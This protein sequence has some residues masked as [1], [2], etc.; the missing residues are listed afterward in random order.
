[1]EIQK[2][3][4]ILEIK[5]C[6]SLTE[7]D[8]KTAYFRQARKYHPD[9]L[10]QETGMDTTTF[11]EIQDAYTCVLQWIRNPQLRYVQSPSG[12]KPDTY[13]RSMMEFISEFKLRLD[14]ESYALL[15]QLIYDYS[16]KSTTSSYIDKKIYCVTLQPTIDHLL[17]HDI[18]SLV[19][20]EE[21]YYIP[22]W[23]EQVEF[24]HETYK[25]VV[26]I[27]PVLPNGIFKDRHN[28]LYVYQSISIRELNG[29]KT[30]DVFIGKRKFTINVSELNLQS[31]IS[32]LQSG[33]ASISTTDMFSIDT[34]NPVY[35]YV[36]F[37][38]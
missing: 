14:K 7:R 11:I 3:C 5:P 13:L 35:I 30:Y 17:N 32:F 26:N 22:L 12:P 15:Q 21:T 37:T 10:K 31:S 16:R 28:V 23:H 29:K 4:D 18:Y 38:D 36:V 34:L 33:I 19:F 2:A 8:A 6:K 24:I 27:D 25:V 1:M 9:K 20:Q